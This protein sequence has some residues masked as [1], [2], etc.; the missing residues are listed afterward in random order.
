MFKM[1]AW[2]RACKRALIAGV[3]LFRAAWAEC[4]ATVSTF[5]KMTTSLCR[6][7]RVAPRKSIGDTISHLMW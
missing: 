6:T 5:L 7:M 3:W 1:P 2:P 4:K